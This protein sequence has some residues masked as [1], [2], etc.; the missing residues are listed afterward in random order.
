MEESCSFLGSYYDDV[1]ESRRALGQNVIERNLG[2]ESSIDAKLHVKI[3]MC[4]VFS[5]HTGSLQR[6]RSRGIGGTET[7]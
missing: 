2:V 6:V 4:F 7:V 3:S 5:T 1:M